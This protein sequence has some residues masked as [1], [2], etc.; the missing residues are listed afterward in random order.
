MCQNLYTNTSG[1]SFIETVYVPW[2]KNY[3][4]IHAEWV[5]KMKFGILNTVMQV[6]LERRRQGVA[7]LPITLQGFWTPRNLKRA[8]FQPSILVIHVQSANCREN[9]ACT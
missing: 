4:Y 9:S 3:L 7:N 2:P 6:M 5:L 1:R 8:Y